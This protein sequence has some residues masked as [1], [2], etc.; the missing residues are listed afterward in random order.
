MMSG[1][2]AQPGS[3]NW[4]HSQAR[5]DFYSNLNWMWKIVADSG[6]CAK[7]IWITWKGI[8]VKENFNRERGTAIY[9][10]RTFSKLKTLRTEFRK[11]WLFILQIAQIIN[12][13]CAR[14]VA[15]H[16]SAFQP[17]VPEW[18]R[19]RRIQHCQARAGR[20]CIN[21][22]ISSITTLAIRGK[23]EQCCISTRSNCRLPSSIQLYRIMQAA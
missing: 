5:D 21:D 13:F 2:V 10:R 4:A 9:T 23:P 19:T 7:R 16:P 6:A 8:M 1:R 14:T 17:V 3:K 20:S 11:S 22:V 12:G 15:V 18:Y